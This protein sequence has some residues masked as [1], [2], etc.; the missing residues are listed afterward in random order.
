[1]SPAASLRSASPPGT[2]GSLHGDGRAAV[3][4]P[5]RVLSASSAALSNWSRGP[6]AA[7]KRE[8]VMRKEKGRGNR[9]A[10]MLPVN[11]DA[12]RLK[13]VA[14]AQHD[15]LRIITRQLLRACRK[16]R[17]TEW[18][19]AER[20]PGRVVV[21]NLHVLPDHPV[22]VRE[23]GLPRD[24]VHFAIG[25]FDSRSLAILRLLELVHEL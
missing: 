24:C 3:T 15:A 11:R 25:C 7:R 13:R 18:R 4:A 17:G 6:G 2:V 23:V 9:R 8:G 22:A 12:L 19:R 1:M 16:G 21:V 20:A 5:A 10:P 14:D